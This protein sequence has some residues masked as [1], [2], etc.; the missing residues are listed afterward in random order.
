MDMFAERFRLPGIHSIALEPISEP[1][2]ALFSA[3]SGL[4]SAAADNPQ[5]TRDV[6]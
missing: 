2:V 3:L 5:S 4:A 1:P 6:R